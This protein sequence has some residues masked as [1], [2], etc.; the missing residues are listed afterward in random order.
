VG[1]YKAQRVAT[2]KSVMP[3][4]YQNCKKIK[5]TFELLPK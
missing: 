1:G 3:G 4:T 2:G 5:G